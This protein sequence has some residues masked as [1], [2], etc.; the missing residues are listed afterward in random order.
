MVAYHVQEPE[1][2]RALM[3]RG[4]LEEGWVSHCYGQ[5]ESAPQLVAAMSNDN[6]GEGRPR[7]KI[8]QLRKQRFADVHGRLREKYRKTARTAFRRLN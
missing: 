7:Q 2:A 8:H 1:I 3:I 4:T 6:A 5:R